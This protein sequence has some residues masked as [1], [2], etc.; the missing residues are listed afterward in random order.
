MDTTLN[1][2]VRA[3]QIQSPKCSLAFISGTDESTNDSP[4]RFSGNVI[5]LHRGNTEPDNQTITSKTQAELCFEN[6]KWYIQ[7]KSALKTTYV[8]AGERK[9]IK[10][11]D[12]I[13]LGN[14]SFVFNCVQANQAE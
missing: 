1:P 8:Y 7:D 6:D 3:E 10:P 5:L 13:V 4:L 11:G 12:I 14:R 9:E 2:W